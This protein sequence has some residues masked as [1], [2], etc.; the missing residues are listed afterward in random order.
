[1]LTPLGAIDI[2][3]S[4]FSQRCKVFLATDLTHRPPRRELEEQDMESA[5]FTR[6]D[7]ERMVQKGEC[8]LTGVWAAP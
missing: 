1:M 8:R 5:W 4:M 6:A 3:P 7:V 2:T